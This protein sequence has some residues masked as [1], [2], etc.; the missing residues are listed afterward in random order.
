MPFSLFG[1]FCLDIILLSETPRGNIST[2]RQ[3]L[4]IKLSWNT[5]EAG[6]V[7]WLSL[8]LD[9]AVAWTK[10]NWLWV[11]QGRMGLC[12]RSGNQLVREGKMSTFFF[13]FWWIVTLAEWWTYCCGPSRPLGSGASDPHPQQGQCQGSGGCLCKS[14][15][16]PVF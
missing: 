3:S 10:L 16:Q 6:R 11:N 12:Q 7:D 1:S 13:F 2:Q 14:W 4:V 8:C 15:S 5:D 9:A